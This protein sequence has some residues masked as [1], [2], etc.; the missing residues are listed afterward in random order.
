MHHDRYTVPSEEDYEPASNNQVLNNLLGIKEKHVMEEIEE[1]ELERTGSE[2]PELYG[3]NHQF[4]AVDV[5]D[6]H[7]LWLASIYPFAGKY[8]TVAMSKD[9]FPFAAPQFIPQCLGELGTKYLSRYTPCQFTVDEELAYALG[10][11]H[12]EFIL[13]HPFREGNGRTARL[14][15]NL[16]SLQ[17]GRSVLNYEPIDRTLNPEG[18]NNYITAI[19]RGVDRDYGLIRDIFLELLRVSES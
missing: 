9:G 11:V 1:R 13:I 16:M 14:L 10:I 6:I 17:A 8:R 7:A 12:V 18:F 2:L 19:H 3:E 4:S 5:C 15:A